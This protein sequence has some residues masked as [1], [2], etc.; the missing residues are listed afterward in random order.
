MKE[1]VK[2]GLILMIISAVA[3]L[4]LAVVYAETK[5]VIDQRAQRDILDAAKACIP[6]A[7]TIEQMEKDG[8]VY[9]IGKNGDE[10]VGAAVR[11]LAQGFSTNAPIE[12]MV[13]VDSQGQVS[14][15]KIISLA[16]TPGIGSRVKSDDFLGRF[17]GKKDPSE[18]D[19]I[20]GATISSSAVKGGAQ[21][22]VEFLSAFVAPEP[23]VVIDLAKIPDGTYEG[24][25]KGLMGPIKVSVAVKD[26]KITKVTVLEN[27]ETPDVAG[28]AL[29]GIPRAI[30]EQQKVDVDAV[31][32]ATFSS[33]GIVGAV[34]N[35]LQGAQGK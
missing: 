9:W 28:P 22:A 33:K 35:A 8:K 25:G 13:G 31:S 6:G 29:T 30:V 7:S 1:V 5:P 4:G 21:N 27:E 12:M 10:L 23:E 32:G 18:V 26:G 11:V 2:L 17:I 20:S 3:G 14:S 19:G 15:I 24:T 34:K 16:E